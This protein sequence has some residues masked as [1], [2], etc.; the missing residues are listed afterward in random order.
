MG[1]RSRPSA[2]G[3]PAST[4]SVKRDTLQERGGG[5]PLRGRRARSVDLS[6]F[7]RRMRRLEVLVLS[8]YSHGSVPRL[9]SKELRSMLD[10]VGDA[11]SQNRG[12]AVEIPEGRESERNVHSDVLHRQV[13]RPAEGPSKLAAAIAHYIEEEED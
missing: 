2:S 4:K 3:N 1:R 9:D 13:V 11:W 12:E 6:P 10:S 7:F 5:R 8:L